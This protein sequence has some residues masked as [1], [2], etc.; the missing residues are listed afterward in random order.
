MELVI[1]FCGRKFVLIIYLLKSFV[2]VLILI[3]SWWIN[4]K[5]IFNGFKI[6]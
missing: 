4:Y 2:L 3:G 6:Y 5:I 1:V